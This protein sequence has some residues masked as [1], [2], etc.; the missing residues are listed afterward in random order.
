MEPSDR[1]GPARGRHV[2][3]RHRALCVLPAACAF[4]PRGHF[5]GRT[6]AGVGERSPRVQTSLVNTV[7]ATHAK[8]V[9]SPT[10]GRTLW[11]GRSLQNMRR[12]G[13][14]R[15][16]RAPGD[17]QVGDSR[18][19]RPSMGEPSSSKDNFN[20]GLA[21]TSVYPPAPTDQRSYR[22]CPI[23]YPQTEGA[24]CWMDGLS[25]KRVA[26]EGWQGRVSD[27]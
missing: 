6:P 23:W 18:A 9:G 11:V 7:R 20:A 2:S 1:L 19:V 5:P 21:F 3:P 8:P 26:E 15:G 12:V 16:P 22:K 25:S 13:A 4:F 10:P 17:A 27:P 14:E 24:G